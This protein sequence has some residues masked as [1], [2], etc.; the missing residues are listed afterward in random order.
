MKPRHCFTLGLLLVLAA[1]SPAAEKPPAAKAPTP[2]GMAPRFK[3]VRDRIDTLYQHRNNPPAPPVAAENPFRPAAGAAGAATST[4]STATTPAEASATDL[5]TLQQ[6]V[7]A[8]RVSG[9]VETNGQIHLVINSRPYK[10]GDVV[11]AAVNGEP[12]YL[13][14]REIGRNIVTLALNETEMDLKFGVPPRTRKK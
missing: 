11:P 12:V 2:S 13:R 14:V 4:G 7:A 8:L 5:Q 3:Q 1:A 9:I 6:A 10:I